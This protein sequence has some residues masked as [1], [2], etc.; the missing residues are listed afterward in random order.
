M[1]SLLC[2]LGF[3]EWIKMVRP[4]WVLTDDRGWKMRG[5]RTVTKCAHCGR[6]KVDGK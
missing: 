5:N 2:K 1:R 4:E 3:H 6:K